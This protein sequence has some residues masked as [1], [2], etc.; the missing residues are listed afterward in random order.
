MN[1]LGCNWDAVVV[2]MDHH[3][4]LSGFED[5][6]SGIAHEQVVHEMFEV[7]PC[8]PRCKAVLRRRLVRQRPDTVVA[9]TVGPILTRTGHA[10]IPTA[11]LQ[12]AYILLK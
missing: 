11:Y 4:M 1:A 10:Y 3:W 9:R 5:L 8:Y 7:E 12:R 2:A 6:P